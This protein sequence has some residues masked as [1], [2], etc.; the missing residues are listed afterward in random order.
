MGVAAYAAASIAK[1]DP[2][3]TGIQSFTYDIRDAIIPFMFILNTDLI[4]Y[5]ITNMWLGI[6]IGAMGILGA[7]SFTSAFQG[8]LII[9]NRW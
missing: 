5:N 9:K 8:W 1:S 7:L 4:L 6:L 2:I 3:K